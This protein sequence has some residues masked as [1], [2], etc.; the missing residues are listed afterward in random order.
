M[1]TM[2]QDIVFLSGKMDLSWRT[3]G[4]FAVFVEDSL[5]HLAVA[6]LSGIPPFR[7]D[8]LDSVDRTPNDI[9]TG[10]QL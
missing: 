3:V 10:S 7:C 8:M 9:E 1:R 4:P 5:H 6:G 2:S